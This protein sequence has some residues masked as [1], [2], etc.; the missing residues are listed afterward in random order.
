MS[1]EPGA[2]KGSLH[3]LFLLVV[4]LV[5][6]ASAQGDAKRGQYLAQAGEIGRAHV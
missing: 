5:G 3:A 6:S 1:D 2:L 4:V